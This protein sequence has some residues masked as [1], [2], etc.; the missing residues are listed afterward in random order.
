MS[1]GLLTQVENQ[2]PERAVPPNTQYLR[3]QADIYFELA[4]QMSLRADADVFRI[5]AEDYMTRAA[6]LEARNQADKGAIKEPE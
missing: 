3:A 1:S 4:R 5:T 2:D 6:Q